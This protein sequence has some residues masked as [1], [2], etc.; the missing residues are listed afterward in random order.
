MPSCNLAPSHLGP[1]CCGHA[2]ISPLRHC[3]APPVAASY[4]L[5]RLPS[6]QC[7]IPAF[8]D[9]LGDGHNKCLLKLLYRTVEWHGFAK[10]RLHTQATL[11]HLE[12]LTKECGRLMRNFRDLT[13]S[14]FET[15]ELQREV[16]ARKRAQQRAQARGLSKGSQSIS[17]RQKRTFN[18]LTPKFHALGDYVSTIQLFGTT[19]SYSTQV[20]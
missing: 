4:H 2:P 6:G 15:K 13:C 9:L 17:E 7:A 12:S 5:C 1:S 20:V 19:D 8:E 10:L 3:L 16:D 14:Q 18:L 11:D